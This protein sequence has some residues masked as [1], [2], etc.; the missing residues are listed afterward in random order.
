MT[1]SCMSCAQAGT[2]CCKNY[3]VNLTTGDMHRISEFLG[4]QDFSTIEPPVLEDI[5]P[6]Y[7]PDWLPLIVRPDGMVRV[8]KKDRER[9]CTMLTPTGCQLPY[10]RRPLIC[11]LYP[12]TYTEKGI[13]GVDSACPISKESD[14][15]SVLDRLDMPLEKAKKCLALIY[16][17]FK[18]ET[19]EQ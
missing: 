9:Y 19:F 10:D 7:D 8:L 14:C 5:E 1:L 11:R 4:H 18:S 12:Y 2:S 13:V 15:Q 16:A 17:E 6:K 3:Q